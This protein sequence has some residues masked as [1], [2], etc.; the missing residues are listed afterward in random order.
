MTLN[1]RFNLKCALRTFIAGFGFDRMQNVTWGG[2][3]GRGSGLEGLV[4]SMWAADA[5]FLCGSWASCFVNWLIDW[6]NDWLIFVCNARY[7]QASHSSWNLDACPEINTFD[8]K[9]LK[10]ILQK[11]KAVTVTNTS[12][13]WLL[14]TH[15]FVPVWSQKYLQYD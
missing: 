9:I 3:L 12:R 5:L 13:Y 2:S 1:A 7:L 8:P 6:L 4:P 15:Y 14:G 10:F 11:L